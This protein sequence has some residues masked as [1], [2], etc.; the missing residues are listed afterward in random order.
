MDL[1]F[2]TIGN[3]TVICYDGGP[4]L[5]TDP[6]LSGSC[7]FGS[8][9]HQCE[10]PEAQLEAVRR[11]P[12]LWISH[13]H[14]DHL[15]HESLQGLKDKEILLPDHHGGR[16]RRELAEEGF[17]VRVLKDGEWVQLS[18][19]LRICSMADVFQDAALLIDL[20]GRLIAD[21]NDAADHGG[22]PFLVDTIRRYGESY[23]L[24][25]TGYGDA[26]MIHFYDEDG[27]QIPPAAAKREPLGPGIAGLLER[28]GI[29]RYVPFSTMHKY[30]RTDSA[31]ANAHTT[32]PEDMRRGFAS[33]TT[34]ILPPYVH[35]DFTTDEVRGL[36][37]ARNPDTLIA[38]EEFGDNWSD[39]LEAG[40]VEKLRAY[41]GRVTHLR[42]FLGFV[43]FRV[44]GKEHT[45]D[46]NPAFDR[47]ITFETP[48]GSLMT[49]VEWRI[50]DDL[51]I[52]NF[53]KTT[54]HGDWGA[55]GTGALYPDF[56][57]FL[58]KYGDNG[59]ATTP[60]ELRAY[61]ADY[62]ARG[63]TR[64]GEAERRTLAPYL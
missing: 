53:T 55:Q 47:G 10:V 49:A 40:D 51:L 18:D 37:P 59:G 54:L 48:R 9:I 23:L 58:T 61:F 13:G 46:V 20:D 21:T 35:C 5:A 11:A 45:I 33:E 63:F 7:Y 25:L 60:E 52:G 29:R 43:R 57:P 16:I 32:S 38:P 1:G 42:S 17:R 19:R 2:E 62:L 28:Y 44:G 41:F 24:A 27:V 6:W 56:D 39:E 15:H 14:P 31:W 64:F 12:Y 26:D 50:F 30:Q 34:E 22:G 3:A 8:W 36:E 4:Q